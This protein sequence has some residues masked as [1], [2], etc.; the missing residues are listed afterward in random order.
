MNSSVLF[1]CSKFILLG[2]V[3]VVGGIPC[4]MQLHLNFSISPIGILWPFLLV[5]F[6]VF[7]LIGSLI[8]LLW[9]GNSKIL[10][11]RMGIAFMYFALVLP[12]GVSLAERLVYHQQVYNDSVGTELAIAINQYIEEKG[13]CPMSIEE[14]ET[15]YFM[16]E[17]LFKHGFTS[18]PFIY[19]ER[20]GRPNLKYC[21]GLWSGRFFDFKDMKWY[22][23]TL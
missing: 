21:S 22:T 14:L 6:E 1:N 2:V 16:G 5:L 15:N 7:F 19:W 17:P 11:I 20:G 23:S 4:I 3:L 10:P 12:I 8:C 13:I 9:L 18:R